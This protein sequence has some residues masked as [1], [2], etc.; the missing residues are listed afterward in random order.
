MPTIETVVFRTPQSCFQLD[1]AKGI[2]FLQKTLL[3]YQKDVFLWNKETVI[4]KNVN[5]P[6]MA[7]D[8]YH[9]E[10]RAAL[11]KEGWTITRM[12]LTK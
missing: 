3:F 8:K 12:T 1:E 6:T 10:V 11:E 5:R 2:I 9:H 4:S 7:R